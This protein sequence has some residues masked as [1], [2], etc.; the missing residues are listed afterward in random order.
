DPRF[1]RTPGSN[2]PEDLGDLH[3]QTNSPCINQGSWSATTLPPT[4]NEGILPRLIGAGP[5]MGAYEVWAASS[6]VWFVDQALGNDGNPGSPAAPFA[7]LT[8]AVAVASGGNSIQV[9]EGNYGTDRLRIIKSV[10][11][12]NWGSSGLARIGQ[13]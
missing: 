6:G 4:D 13:P 2:G 11:L 8:A 1:V 12:F 3:L 5:D 9:R 7:T 10:H